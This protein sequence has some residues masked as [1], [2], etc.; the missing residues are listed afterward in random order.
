MVTECIKVS[1]ESKTYI[2]KRK[3]AGNHTSRD[4]ALREIIS[5]AEQF[6]ENKKKHPGQYIG[7][8][9]KNGDRIYNGNIIRDTLNDNLYKVKF[10]K[11]RF[12]GEFVPHDNICGGYNI[13]SLHKID[14]NFI[15]LEKE[16][17]N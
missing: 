3:K 5:E 6:R 8:R 17:V 14:F 7:L 4:S 16:S 9:D 10:D 11:G 12:Y 15:V 1:P 13:D 2:D